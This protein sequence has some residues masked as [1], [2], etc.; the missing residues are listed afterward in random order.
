MTLCQATTLGD[1]RVGASPRRYAAPRARARAARVGVAATVVRQ[2]GE[3]NRPE[4]PVRALT[5]W[6]TVRDGV[7][8]LLSVLPCVSTR[9][10]CAENLLH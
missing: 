5:S 9:M 6:S 8:L 2:C 7:L 3:V 1:Q 4:R 10:F